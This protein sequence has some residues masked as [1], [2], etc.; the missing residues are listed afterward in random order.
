MA[1]IDCVTLVTSD[2]FTG[3]GVKEYPD[4]STFQGVFDQG[5]KKSGVLDL[6]NGDSYAGDFKDDL[7]DGYSLYKF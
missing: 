7:F 2:D 1:E 4:G 3:K 6:Q 5:R